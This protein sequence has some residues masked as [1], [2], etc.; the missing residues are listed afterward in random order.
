MLHNV[1]SSIA[2]DVFEFEIS[3]VFEFEFKIPTFFIP[4]L[5]SAGIFFCQLEIFLFRDHFDIN[6][7][8]ESENRAIAAP[9]QNLSVLQGLSSEFT[10]IQ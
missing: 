8:E 5:F 2:R 9:T 6:D 3:E 7:V 10:N 1:L 4:A